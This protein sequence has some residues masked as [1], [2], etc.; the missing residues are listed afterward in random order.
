MRGSGLPSAMAAG[1]SF[2]VLPRL[3][4]F[5]ADQLVEI[6]ALAARR[7]LLI[8]QGE[9]RLIEFLEELLPGNLLERIVLG[10][11][12]AGKFEADDAGVVLAMGCAH[13]RRASAA[14]LCPFANLV[15]IGGDFRVGHA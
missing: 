11:R 13:R 15:V 3:G 5:A 14:R 1:V 7:F 12:C 2:A 10:M 8:K 6:A 9:T 4:C